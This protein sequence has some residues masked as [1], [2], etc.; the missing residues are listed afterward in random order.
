MSDIDAEAPSQ[1][2]DLSRAPP[3]GAAPPATS[4][5]SEPDDLARILSEFDEATAK[6]QPDDAAANA[7]PPAE[8]QSIE[9]IN[10]KARENYEREQITDKALRATREQ[11]DSLS[12][13]VQALR[14][15]ALRRQDNADFD[16]VLKIANE[17]IDDLRYLPPDFARTW[18]LNELQT[19]ARLRH[20]VARRYESPAARAAAE[21]RM[22]KAM[23]K[24]AAA[25]SNRPDPIVSG[26]VAAV[27]AAV[28][29]GSG[30]APEAKA[31]D[32]AR[33]NDTD[34]AAAKERLWG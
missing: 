24:L 14:A 13:T 6:Q 32:F 27:S 29:G 3:A 5:A 12:S 20:A 18:L 1:Q 23:Q 26:D 17:T 15:E 2:V 10:N 28:R 33:M 9:D 34:F 25:A 11:I 16:N 31:P 4:A 22:E 21:H 19:D 30:R 7:A 8:P